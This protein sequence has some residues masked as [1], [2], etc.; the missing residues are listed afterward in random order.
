MKINASVIDISGDLSTT[1][2]IPRSNITSDY[3][4]YLFALNNGGS[5]LSEYFATNMKLY[6]F[7]YYHN[8]TLAQHL[9][10]AL[11]NGVPCLYDEVSG[12]FKYNAGTGTFNYA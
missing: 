1:Y 5:S 3:P 4:V 8:G 7:K 6:Y 2:S 12:T 10:P 9:V 11:N